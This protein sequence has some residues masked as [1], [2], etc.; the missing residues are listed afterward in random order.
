[1]S[2]TTKAIARELDLVKLQPGDDCKHV[3]RLLDNIDRLE[4]TLEVRK[5]AAA[6]R[7]EN[8]QAVTVQ[9]Q[10]ERAKLN[11]LANEVRNAKFA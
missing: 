9:A 7:V 8:D 6:M 5:A 10:R 11:Q 3:D 2:M 4:R 1:M